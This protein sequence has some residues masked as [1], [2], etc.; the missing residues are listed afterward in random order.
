MAHL[1]RAVR[2]LVGEVE[3]ERLGRVVLVDDP[4]GSVSEQVCGVV[5]TGAV[6]YLVIVSEVV[7]TPATVAGGQHHE[8]DR[9]MMQCLINQ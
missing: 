3:E 7:S 8:H 2:G 6:V 5:T 9:Q 1:Q 4:R